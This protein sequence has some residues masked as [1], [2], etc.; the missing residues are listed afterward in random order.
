ML[1]KPLDLAKLDAEI[2]ECLTG[3]QR[4]AHNLL[5]NKGTFLRRTHMIRHFAPFK[6]VLNFAMATSLALSS[7]AFAQT[8]KGQITTAQR[9]KMGAMHKKMADMHSKMAACLESDKAPSQCRQEML[10]T[11]SANF[12]GSCPMMGT[13]MMGKG[14]M[15]GGKGMGMMGDGSCMDWMMNPDSA[16]PATSTPAK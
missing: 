11:C 1:K 16:G 9:Q 2:F 14:K 8:P 4:L 3:A 7:A 6:L 13:G 12:G 15:G 10:D 5:K